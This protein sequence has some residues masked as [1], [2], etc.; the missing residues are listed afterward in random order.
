MLFLSQSKQ[1]EGETDAE[2]LAAQRDG[3]ADA[4]PHRH[5][6]KLKA[7]EAKP[8]WIWV[9]PKTSVRHRLTW[10]QARQFYCNW[11]ERLARAQPEWTRLKRMVD[12]GTNVLLVGYDAV[13]CPDGVE[14][15]YLSTAAS[16]GHERVLYAMLTIANE[17]DWPWRKHKTFDF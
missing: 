6:R 9:D 15:A 3:F 12:E 13:P 5:K 14:A 7:G 4:E 16:F 2:F 8:S 1:F 17:D 10:V 11:Y